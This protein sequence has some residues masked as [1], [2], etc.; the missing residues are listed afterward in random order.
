MLQSSQIHN[1]LANRHTAWQFQ[2][3]HSVTASECVN[4]QYSLT[5]GQDRWERTII[6]T[7]GLM[8]SQQLENSVP[9]SKKTYH[10]YKDQLID[11]MLWKSKNSIHT[12]RKR[13][14]TII[15]I[16]SFFWHHD[17]HKTQFIPQRNMC[18]HYKDKVA[19][20]TSQ[21]PE[22]SVPTSRKAQCITTTKI[23]WL[24][25]LYQENAFSLWQNFI[26]FID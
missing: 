12:S 13:H 5:N 24:M 17:S 8:L 10:H 25:T 26:V 20:L 4:F 3:V 16:N 9:T 2:Y 22:N 18:H 11:L 21:Q 19:G 7:D 1:K 6:R 23:K 15:K 14:V